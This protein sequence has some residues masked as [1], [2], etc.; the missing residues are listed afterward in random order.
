MFIYNFLYTYIKMVNKYYQKQKGKA[1]KRRTQK[2]SKPFWQRKIIQT[3]KGLRGHKN[4][5][6]E[7]REK[8]RQYHWDQNIL[9]KKK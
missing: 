9:T 7:E 4:L 3:K 1:S 6:G 5:S 2:I 8:K